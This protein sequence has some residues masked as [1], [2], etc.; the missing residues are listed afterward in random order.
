MAEAGIP[1]DP[2][3]SHLIKSLNPNSPVTPEPH[4]TLARRLSNVL[5][6]KRGRP[7]D[8]SVTTPVHESKSLSKRLAAVILKILKTV[9]AFWSTFTLRFFKWWKQALQPVAQWRSRRFS[10]QA[11]DMLD[12]G[13]ISRAHQLLN[14]AVEFDS[15]N[16]AA[17]LER[18]GTRQVMND[19]SGAEADFRQCLTICNNQAPAVARD[20]ADNCFCGMVRVLLSQ[21][22]I[23]EALAFGEQ[24]E[25]S[26]GISGVLTA[27]EAHLST[28]SMYAR[29]S[30]S[31]GMGGQARDYYEKALHV[32]T[33]VVFL[34]Q[35]NKY[36]SDLRI[37]HG[38]ALYLM[39]EHK[40]ASQQ[41][42]HG[43]EMEKTSV[44][45]KTGYAESLEKMGDKDQAL[46]A[47]KEVLAMDPGN[48][49]VKRNVG[50]LE[51]LRDD[52]GCT[53]VTFGRE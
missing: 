51:Q 34:R 52:M 25:T 40:K 24:V 15:G 6:D 1:A 12:K 13:H 35:D 48:S 47:Y 21:G 41:F 37:G 16:I 33:A 38:S 53:V 28:M 17:L 29:H 7:V 14:K 9:K 3:A 8:H 49:T 18:G 4:S 39:G 22:K 19:L 42:K 11:K 50:R 36:S 20:L 5:E 46:L 32:E 10:R 23:D 43:F 26:E 44:L 45:A 2:P 27:F 30:L 31:R